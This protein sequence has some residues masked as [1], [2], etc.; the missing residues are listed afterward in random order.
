MTA[1]NVGSVLVNFNRAR[2]RWT[3]WRPHLG[4]VYQ[5]GT[6]CQWKYKCRERQDA[7]S[8]P[9]PAL[10]DSAQRIPQ[11]HFLRILIP[12]LFLDLEELETY[13]LY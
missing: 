10:R 13:I 8:D 7:G 1:S 12:I 6:R 2:L 5:Q 4:L 9:Q 3:S 11:S